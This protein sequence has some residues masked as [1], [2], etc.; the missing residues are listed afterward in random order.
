MRTVFFALTLALLGNSVTGGLRAEA[1]G[2]NQDYL[3]GLSNALADW[4]DVYGV[5][6]AIF[7]DRTLPGMLN[8]DLPAGNFTALSP[9][10]YDDP[11]SSLG[12]LLG[13]TDQPVS[14]D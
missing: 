13:A 12:E 3:T 4:R 1:H 14:P 2:G 11:T 6:N 7:G 9:E 8:L 5:Y 10:F